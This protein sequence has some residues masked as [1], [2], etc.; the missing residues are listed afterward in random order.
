MRP[1]SSDPT[2]E[3]VYELRPTAP[4]ELRVVGP[5]RRERAYLARVAG[6]E[7]E[8][9]RRT[10]ELELSALV[11]RGATRAAD[12]LERELAARLRDRRALEAVQ[13]RLI[14]ALGALQREN[15]LL[16]AELALPGGARRQLGAAPAAVPPA[17]P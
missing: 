4:P 3:P 11:E 14:L 16:R 5:G 9:V 1:A 10:R 8:L 7:G 15:E 6:L 17:R 2:G 12:R 13:K